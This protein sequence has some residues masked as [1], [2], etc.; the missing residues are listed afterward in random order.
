MSDFAERLE[1][2][3][4]TQVRVEMAERGINQ[5]QLARATG[6]AVAS[7]SRYLRNE[8]HYPLP[9]VA[10]LAAGL[11]LTLDVLLQRTLVRI[12]PSGAS[13]G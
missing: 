2:A 3:L 12:T 6:M 9:V 11:G 10:T 4:S 5:Q 7:M 1:E 13:G 8:R